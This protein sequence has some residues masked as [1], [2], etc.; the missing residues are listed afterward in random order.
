VEEFKRLK[1]GISPDLGFFIVDLNLGG[2]V[3]R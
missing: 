3:N 1:V 2:W